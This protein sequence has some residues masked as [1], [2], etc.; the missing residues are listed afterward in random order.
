MLMQ[1]AICP[2]KVSYLPSPCSSV[3]LILITISCNRVVALMEGG[4]VWSSIRNQQMISDGAW[5]F[6]SLRGWGRG[7]E[8]RGSA[9]G[10]GGSRWHFLIERIEGRRIG[11]GQVWEQINCPCRSPS[12]A[13]VSK[14]VFTFAL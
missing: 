1:E 14:G 10:S 2:Y 7:G 5:Q 3:S 12:L 8:G 11:V 13:L 4:L 6:P 9:Q